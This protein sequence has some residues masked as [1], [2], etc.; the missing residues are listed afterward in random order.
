MGIREEKRKQ[1]LSLL[2]QTEKKH[3]NEGRFYIAG[4]DEA[5]RGPLAGPVVA[6]CAVMPHDRLILGVDDSKKLSEK[7]REDLYSKVT[8][9]A[10]DWS[11]GIVDQ[12]AIDQIN[13][14]N[15]AK[16]AFARALDGLRVKPDHIY[17]DAMGI[18]TEI[19]YTSV[20]KGDSKIY[21]IAAAS[22]IAKVTRDGIMRKYDEQYPNYGFAK[23]KGYGTK[24]HYDALRRYGVTDL[25]RK[26]FLKKFFEV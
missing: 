19:P 26:S 12:N 10:L 1:R 8:E 2:I 13:I 4:M 24:E 15:A 9:T 6:A 23:H 7:R 17:T 5:G 20:V 25:H 11:V 18:V 22:I 16:L 14:L 21:C 3:W